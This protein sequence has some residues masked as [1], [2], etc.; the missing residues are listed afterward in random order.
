MSR[1]SSTELLHHSPVFS[2]ESNLMS[3]S[4][5]GRGFVLLSSRLSEKNGNMPIDEPSGGRGR[6]LAGLRRLDEQGLDRSHAKVFK[7][8]PNKNS[9]MIHKAKDLSP[10]QRLA[11]ESL[12]GCSIGENEEII[13]RTTHSPSHRSG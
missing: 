2:S 10:D 11:I 5:L 4:I 3:Y 13:I 12:L 7:Q 8:G 6:T 1:F 9:S